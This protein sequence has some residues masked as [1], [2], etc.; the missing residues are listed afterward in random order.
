MS[1]RQSPYLCRQTVAKSRIGRCT[2][3]QQ[4]WQTLL[5]KS[6]M[7]LFSTDCVQPDSE[8]CPPLIIRSSQTA[9]TGEADFVYEGLC[10]CYTLWEANSTI[11]LCTK[12]SLVLVHTIPRYLLPKKPPTT[13]ILTLPVQA[14][15]A[16]QLIWHSRNACYG[17]L[18]VSYSRN[19]VYTDVLGCMMRRRLRTVTGHA[20]LNEW[21]VSSA[22]LFSLCQHRRQCKHA[23]WAC[24]HCS[25]C[26]PPLI[27][28]LD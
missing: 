25:V 4:T 6:Y 10:V 24:L 17:Q 9:Y 12:K 8:R 22:I 28:M 15:L 23:D 26:W 3:L 14:S 13:G 19:P 5:W 11:V 16:I 1:Q 18:P 2:D 27:V 20:Q 7:H 21:A